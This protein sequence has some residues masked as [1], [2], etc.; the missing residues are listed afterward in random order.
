MD[1]GSVMAGIN[2]L[3]VV[4][5]AVSTFVLGGLW[6]GPLFGKAWMGASGVTEEQARQ[7]NQ[8][9]IFGLAFVC[10]LIAAVLLAM[11]L[12]AESTL[13]FGSF[14]GAS[15]GIGW[16]GTGLAVI[17]L[18]ERRPLPHWVVNGGYQAVAFTMMGAILG[19]WH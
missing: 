2:W 18:F 13:A 19:A 12:G 16:V 5:A 14:A 17:Y 15:V 4:V 8:G 3:A 7:G 1:T 11:F 6:Y 9:M 10:E